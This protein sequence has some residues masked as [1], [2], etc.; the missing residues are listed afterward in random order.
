MCIRSSK[1]RLQR[2]SKR[3][4]EFGY[5]K[6]GYRTMSEQMKLRSGHKG[7]GIPGECG[8]P[9]MK[10]ETLNRKERVVVSIKYCWLSNISSCLH[11]RTHFG[12]EGYCD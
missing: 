3:L 7:K 11:S 9:E 1:V 2:E 10:E 6:I 5:L 4:K 8:V 12:Y